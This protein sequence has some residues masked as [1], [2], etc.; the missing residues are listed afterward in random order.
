LHKTSVLAGAS[1]LALVTASVNGTAHASDQYN[2][3]VNWSTEISTVVAGSSS[4]SINNNQNNDNLDVLAPVSNALM[5]APTSGIH[6]FN[7]LDSVTVDTLTVFSAGT[8][9][10]TPSPNSISFWA[11]TGSGASSAATIASIQS[12]ENGSS[13]NT[14][15]SDSEIRAASSDLF[16][17]SA[18]QVTDNTIT[19]DAT[20]HDVANVISGDLNPLLSSTEGGFTGISGGPTLGNPSTGT[21]VGASATALIAT[22]Q[23]LSIATTPS[24]SIVDNSRIGSLILAIDTTSTVEDITLDV[25]GNSIAA[26]ITGNTAASEINLDDDLDALHTSAVTL[27][28]SAGIANEQRITTSG[29]TIQAQITASE[30]EAGLA[31]ATP[32]ANLTGSTIDFSANDITATGAGNVA[33]NLVRLGEGISQAGTFPF[34]AISVTR[35][36]TVLVNGSGS[37]G[38]INVIGDL[39]VASHQFSQLAVVADVGDATGDTD[40]GDLNVLVESIVGSTIDA[41]GNAIAASAID[42]QASNA[43]VV[44]GATTLDSLVSLGNAQILT[45]GS[46]ADATANGDLTISMATLGTV[47]GDI[48]GSAVTISGNALSAAAV[49][50]V[51]A[52]GIDLTGTDV[53]SADVNPQFNFVQSAHVLTES[54]VAADFGLVSGQFAREAEF[55]ASTVGSILVDAADVSGAV[56][57]SIVDSGVDVSANSIGAFAVAN[58]ITDNSFTAGADGNMTSFDGTV[59]VI[60]LQIAE[61]SDAT[62]T[63]HLSISALVSF[64]DDSLDGTLIDVDATA[65]QVDQASFDVDGNDISARVFGNLAGSGANALHVEAVTVSDGVPTPTDQLA[66]PVATVY[67]SLTDAVIPNAS[68]DGLPDTVVQGGFVVV[69]DQSVEDIAANPL[70]SSPWTATVTAS[71]A[72]NVAVGSSAAGATV[73][74]TEVG[75]DD[76]TVTAAV[77][78]NQGGNALSVKAGS[79]NGTSTLVNTQSF[80][81]EDGGTSTASGAIESSVQG[82]IIAGVSAGATTISD[83]DV[84]MSANEVLA[85]GRIN[86]AANSV[87]IDAQQQTVLD[88]VTGNDVNSV[89]MG[90]ATVGGFTAGNTLLRAETGLLNSQEFGDL[91]SMSVTLSSVEIAAI[92]STSDGALADSVIEISDNSLTAQALGNDA[93]NALSLNVDTFDLTDAGSSTA[94]NGPL[95]VIASHQRGDDGGAPSVVTQLIGGGVRADISAVDNAATGTDIAADGNSLRSLARINN[96]T[97]TLT[98]TGQVY[99][100]AVV[101]T[102]AIRV[103]D[104]AAN[105]E[106]ATD[107]LAFGIASYQLNAAGATSNILGGTVTVSAGNVDVIDG[108]ALS[109]SDNLTVAEVRS[110]DVVNDLSVAFTS[111]H[112][113]AFVTSLQ[114]SGDDGISLST[115]NA[116]VSISVTAD[117]GAQVLTGSSFEAS[118]NAVAAISSANRST[119]LATAAGTNLTSGTGLT[120]PSSVIAPAGASD[121]T[122]AADLSVVNVQGAEAVATA[123]PDTVGAQVLIGTVLV[124]LDELQTG[125]ASVDNNLMLAQAII[126]NALNDAALDA[127]ATIGATGDAA[128]AAVV[129]RQLV[130]TGSSATASL[131]AN[132]MLLQ[133][134]DSSN[135]GAAAASLSSNQ[136]VGLATSGTATS[137][138]TVEAGASVTGGTPAA[139]P[140]FTASSQTLNA[141]FSVLNVQEGE[142]VAFSDVLSSDLTAFIGNGPASVTDNDTVDVTDNVVQ[143]SATGF[144]T[145]NALTVDAGASSDASG[146]VGNRQSVTAGALLSSNAVS[147]RIQASIFG[148]S[149]NSRVD[150]SDNTVSASASGTAALNTLDTRASSSLQESSGAGGTVDPAAGITVTG[151]DYG[152]L[153]W[154][155]TADATLIATITTATVGVGDLGSQGVNDSA[156]T[157]EGNRIV[158]ATGVN[159]ATNGL[160]LNTGTFQHPSASISSLQTASGTS[161]SASITGATVGIDGPIS[162]TSG[163]SSLAVR[164]NAIGATAVGNS[165]INS[166]SS[167]N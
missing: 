27:N 102:P 126:H 5:G 110:N 37:D 56:G 148:G 16:A 60:S 29:R 114:Q 41:T 79:L 77:T 31:A 130:T 116:F 74:A 92:V 34:G 161:A 7:G 58:R 150:V 129:S 96:A 46:S 86:N 94:T 89:E 12:S 137:R 62:A 50:N 115:L 152:L 139:A 127:A 107:D 135:A 1:I 93:A 36:S 97:N 143:A 38:N 52:N 61:G 71:S 101:A 164:G 42:N 65:L 144:G 141:D 82:N 72:I 120:S 100:E 119:N 131:V 32:V 154:Q 76:N 15:V 39:F 125:S 80:W 118:G 11:A 132:S 18:Q 40:D 70:G 108:S 157:V 156:V 83:I 68:P 84:H 69:N 67:R 54:R 66:T 147:S 20:G 49:G 87:T 23:E 163:N 128:S 88:V 165:A 160:V 158:A 75:V 153:N 2:A 9:A 138:L 159:S 47:T 10:G 73:T 91:S 136:V 105:L 59:G 24:T 146:Q 63:D 22:V 134:A 103:L 78:G 21:M 53:A 35:S 133:I 140:A 113:S 25:T 64:T 55:N 17:G 43:I 95:A 57:S 51:A 6:D 121:V 104:V 109:A 28:G 14:S 85:S 151:S 4:V 98:A 44:A 99:E 111:N 142:T 122:V 117:L 155:S 33:D 167:G 145:T 162:G 26:S 123:T 166:L 81:N 106:V 90:Y 112:L 45:D 8:L 30:I 13:V 149:Q 124:Q 48:A 3:T 19:A